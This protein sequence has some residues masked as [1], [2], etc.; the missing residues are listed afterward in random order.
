MSLGKKLQDHLINTPISSAA[1]GCEVAARIT[2]GQSDVVKG[3]GAI[4]GAQAGAL[5]GGFK[6]VSP[7]SVIETLCR[8]DEE[9][10][11]R[12]QELFG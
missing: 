12:T 4:I 3:L 9:I 6:L 11:K 2:D 1:R 8:S 7:V 10:D 5:M